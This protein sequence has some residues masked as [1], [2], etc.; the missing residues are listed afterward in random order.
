MAFLQSAKE[1]FFHPKFGWKTTNFWGPIANWGIVLSAVYDATNKGP[2]TISPLTTGVLLAY[3]TVFTRFALK[4]Q[5]VNYLLFACHTFNVAAQSYQLYRWSNW[6]NKQTVIAQALPE[7]DKQALLQKIGPGF[8]IQPVATAIATVGAGVLLGQKVIK[9]ALTKFNPV[10]NTTGAKVKDIL[11][12]P[13]G[14]LFIHFWAPIFKWALSISNIL[15]LDRD[16]SQISLPQQTALAATGF[17]WS[18]YSLVITPKNYS[19]FLVNFVLG[20]TG[21]WHIGRKLRAE[22]ADDKVKV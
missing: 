13:A 12:H 9:P 19:L 2:E 1:A 20:L 7:A 4:V 22:F 14:P 15:E 8:P 3:S 11:T 17:I 5:P 6:H 18:R 21:A 16:L 10:A